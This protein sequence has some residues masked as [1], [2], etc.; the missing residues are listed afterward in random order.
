MSDFCLHVAESPFGLIHEVP[1]SS[2]VLCVVTAFSSL[3]LRKL[4]LG[5]TVKCAWSP[6]MTV[7]A[8]LLGARNLL[9][10]RL[11]GHR[12]SKYCIL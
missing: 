9:F 4:K 10:I 6:K 11:L 7:V 5:H 3:T 1:G 12:E 2:A 8:K